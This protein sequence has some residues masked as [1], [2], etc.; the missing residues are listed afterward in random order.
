M[1]NTHSNSLSKKV[2][3]SILDILILQLIKDKPMSGNK[4]LNE[5]ESR[6]S[7]T[8]SPASVYSALSSLQDQGLITTNPGKMPTL[9]E[10]GETVRQQLIDD[11]LKLQKKIEINF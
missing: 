11:Y 7:I 9:T 4:I 6:F 1:D 2:I 10:K 8:L 3:K 5:I